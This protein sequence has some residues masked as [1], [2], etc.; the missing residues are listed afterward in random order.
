MIFLEISMSK[1]EYKGFKKDIKQL[2]AIRIVLSWKN[3]GMTF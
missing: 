2:L 1:Q 3:I